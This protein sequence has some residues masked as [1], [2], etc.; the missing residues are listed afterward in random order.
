MIWIPLLVLSWIY[1][2]FAIIGIYRFKD[3]YSRLLTS[4]LIDTAAFLTI[5]FALIV[6]AGFGIISLKLL[7]IM[8]F[9]LFTGPVNNHLISRSAYLNGIDVKHGGVDK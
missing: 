1:I 5:I 8:I 2:L 6:K 3:L 9:V 7:L 4:S